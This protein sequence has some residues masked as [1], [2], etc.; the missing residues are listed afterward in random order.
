M[1]QLLDLQGKL[2]KAL[3]FSVVIGL[4][5]FGVTFAQNRVYLPDGTLFKVDTTKVRN[6]KQYSEATGNKYLGTDDVP[7]KDK[8]IFFYKPLSYEPVLVIAKDSVTVRN[9]MKLV[10]KAKYQKSYRFR[11]DF[12]RLVDSGFVRSDIIKLLGEPDDEYDKEEVYTVLSYKGFSIQCIKSTYPEYT[13]I[14]KLTIYDIA[15]AKKSGIGIAEFGINLSEYDDD[16]VTGFRASFYNFSAKKIKYIYI[17][18]RADNAVGDIVSTRTVRAIGPIP[19]GEMGS[20]N[21]DSTFYSKIIETVRIT[22]LKVQYFDGTTK[23]VTGPLL[24]GSFV[25]K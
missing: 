9:A 25:E 11:S 10:N 14:D 24:R 3:F 2:A 18:V 22:S 4:V 1:L 21:Y 8:T 6:L 17:T 13:T 20:Y 19:N 5:S 23:L 12:E 7:D 16:V 15:G